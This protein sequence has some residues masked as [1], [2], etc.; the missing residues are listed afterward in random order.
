M[1]LVVYP[2]ETHCYCRYCGSC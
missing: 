1:E 2:K